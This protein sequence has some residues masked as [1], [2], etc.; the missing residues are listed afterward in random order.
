MK[1]EVIAVDKFPRPTVP[2]SYGVKA[3]NLLFIAGQV[4]VDPANNKLRGSSISEQTEQALTNM[5]NVLKA[6]GSSMEHVVKTT[7]FISDFKDF[8]EMNKVYA[9]FFPT[10]QPARSTVQVVIY[11][12]FKVEIEAIAVIP[13]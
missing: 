10:D 1:K 12:G 3:G 5:A 6:A 13:S 7:V 9:K 4:G 2:Y 11:D 8:E